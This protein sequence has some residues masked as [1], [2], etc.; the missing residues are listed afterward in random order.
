MGQE[1]A[2]VVKKIVSQ[3]TLNSKKIRVSAKGEKVQCNF[4]KSKV[5][6]LARHLLK[7]SRNPNNSP[8]IEL[9]WEHAE[10]FKMFKEFLIEKPHTD[11]E[12]EFNLALIPHGDPFESVIND[13]LNYAKELPKAHKDAMLHK[14][15]DQIFTGGEEVRLLNKEEYITRLKEKIQKGY[16][17]FLFD[18]FKPT[19]IED[20]EQNKDE[21][22]DYP[23][24]KK[25]IQ[26]GE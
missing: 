3:T 19:T 1:K 9:K 13:L 4:C 18:P 20:V 21:L 8:K 25:K 26:E 23:P 22:W 16:R 2:Q 15:M 14:K 12:R 10:E 17:M 5:Q 7:C 24:T 6:D 11:K